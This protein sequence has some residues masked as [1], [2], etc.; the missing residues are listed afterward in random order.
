MCQRPNRPQETDRRP[1]SISD[2]WP[3]T[4]GWGS[5]YIHVCIGRVGTSGRGRLQE[6]QER[7]RE[8]LTYIASPDGRIRVRT[9]KDLC[10]A[11][12]QGASASWGFCPTSPQTQTEVDWCESH[13]GGR[14]GTIL[15]A[16]IRQRMDKRGVPDVHDCRG[17]VDR[18]AV[19][20]PDAGPPVTVERCHGG[21][22][23]SQ[24]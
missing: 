3:R 12:S 24:T 5:P 1:Q 17:R 4:Y 11:I 20:K 14:K 23:Q 13:E 8:W 22:V 2:K 6:Y 21:E 18:L 9:G 10:C 7:M 15:R 19:N 16:V